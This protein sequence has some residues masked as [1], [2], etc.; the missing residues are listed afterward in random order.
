MSGPYFV[1]MLRCRGDALYTGMTTDPA[2]RLKEHQS[3]RKSGGARYTA[4]RPPEGFAAQWQVEDRSAA[5]RLE[6]RIK[7]LSR[8]EKL[9]LVAGEREAELGTRM[10]LESIGGK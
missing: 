1:Y 3:G 8:A 4:A 6:A 2:R 7:A 10:P 5:L 9:A